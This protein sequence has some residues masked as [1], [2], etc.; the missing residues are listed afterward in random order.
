MLLNMDRLQFLILL[1]IPSI[2][3]GEVINDPNT[4]E[5]IRSSCS[6]Y[7]IRVSEDSDYEDKFK[8][9]RVS[10][11]TSKFSILTPLWGP[12]RESYLK[13][14]EPDFTISPGVDGWTSYIYISNIEASNLQIEIISNKSNAIRAYWKDRNTVTVEV[15]WGRIAETVFTL[16]ASSGEIIKAESRNHFESIL[17]CKE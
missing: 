9:S 3:L 5:Q 2:G 11:E 8:V 4:G 17:P 14:L 10:T 7:D 16:E 15:W 1:L 6:Y 13:L 12:D